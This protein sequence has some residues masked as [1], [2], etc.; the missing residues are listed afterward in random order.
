MSRIFPT[1]F[2]TGR[3]A[4]RR[5][6]A[7]ASAEKIVAQQERA[8]LAAKSKKEKDKANRIKIRSLRSRKSSSYFAE[9]EAQTIG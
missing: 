4:A 2:K 5:A 9:G 6:Q 1:L 7:E 3:H 8:T